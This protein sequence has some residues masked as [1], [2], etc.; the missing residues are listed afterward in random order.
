MELGELQD[1]AAD[2][3]PEEVGAILGTLRRVGLTGPRLALQL[4]EEECL[5][6]QLAKETGITSRGSWDM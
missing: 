2:G 1:N 6:K 3:S 5:A 4:G